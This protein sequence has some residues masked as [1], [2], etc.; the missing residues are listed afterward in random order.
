MGR[1][2]PTVT[3]SWVIPPRHSAFP[4]AHVSDYIVAAAPC[5]II[6]SLTS[7]SPEFCYIIMAILVRWNEKYKVVRMMAAAA[8]LLNIFSLLRH[9]H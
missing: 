7:F 1:P 6:V 2:V 3:S 8:A 5:S 4:E 9:D